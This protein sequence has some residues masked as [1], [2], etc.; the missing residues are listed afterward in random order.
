[1]RMCLAIAALL[2]GGGA[3]LVTFQRAADQVQAG[4]N[5]KIPAAV[6]AAY[7]DIRDAKDWLNPKITVRAEGIEVEAVGIPKGRK[8]VP[9]GALRDLLISLP[10]SSWPYGRVVLASDIGLRRADR[11]DDEGIR[12]ITRRPKRSS[13]LSTSKPTGGLHDVAEAEI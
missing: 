4:L 13:R 9:V 5:P 11:S 8:T 3:D 10:V 12:R 1:M 7:K 6:H 2:F